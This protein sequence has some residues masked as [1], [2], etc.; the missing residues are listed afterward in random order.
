MFLD[1]WLFWWGKKFS[2]LRR[3]ISPHILFFKL[4]KNLL[5]LIYTSLCD[6]MALKQ[7]SISRFI[8]SWHHTR[9]DNRT[10]LGQ[11]DNKYFFY[12]FYLKVFILSAL[13]HILSWSSWYSFQ[14]VWPRIDAQRIY[15]DKWCPL[16]AERS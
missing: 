8:I 2:R 16:W 11:D 7:L 14:V 6:K 9:V 3:L 12:L 5:V 4:Y 15:F 13:S 1:G 10:K